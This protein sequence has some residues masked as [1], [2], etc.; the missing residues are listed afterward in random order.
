MAFRGRWASTEF[1]IIVMP[2]HCSRLTRHCHRVH[3]NLKCVGRPLRFGSSRQLCVFYA[4]RRAACAAAIHQ[5][6]CVAEPL[7]TK[8][9]LLTRSWQAKSEATSLTDCV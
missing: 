3:M 1:D 4:S 7:R 6:H 8:D 2:L 9:K 5:K